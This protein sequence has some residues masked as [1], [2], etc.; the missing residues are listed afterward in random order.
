MK[1]KEKKKIL[2]QNKKK[3]PKNPPLKLKQIMGL[4]LNP[5]KAHTHMLTRFFW[6]QHRSCV[7]KNF[8][9]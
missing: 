2:K 5:Q 9:V 4:N 1:E 3:H 7:E 8:T 6:E